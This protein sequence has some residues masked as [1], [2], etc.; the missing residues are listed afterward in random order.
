MSDTVEIDLETE[1]A[2]VDGAWTSRDDLW[3]QMNDGVG[4]KDYKRIA[5][6]ASLLEQ[7]DEALA[8]SRTIT[9][10][11]S[12]A[13]FARL[14]AAGQKMNQTPDVF[15]RQ[16]LAQ[17]LGAGTPVAAKAEAAPTQP[18]GAAPL[19][20]EAATHE[21]PPVLTLQPKRRDAGSASAAPGT[22][23]PVMTPVALPAVQPAAEPASS[24]VVDV[25]EDNKSTSD[26]R[27]WFNRT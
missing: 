9:F 27:R 15:A 2:L 23:P 10:K 20:V 12:A 8:G 7:L 22:P 14:E 13:Q 18:A 17:V 6:F 24:V 1:K 5:R 21:E 26:D 16:M 3:T 11:L 4:A 19:A 25:K